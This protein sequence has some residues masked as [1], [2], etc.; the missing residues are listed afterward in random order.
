MLVHHVVPWKPL[1]SLGRLGRGTHE[2]PMTGGHVVTKGLLARLQT[3]HGQEEQVERFLHSTLPLV[4]QEP[5]T[6]AFFAIRFGRHEY[7]IFDVCPGES[8]VAAHLA[9][10]AATGLTQ[11]G[12]ELFAEAPEITRLDV[13]ASKLPT[14]GVAADAVTKGLLLLL[15]AKSG[16]EADVEEF[17]RGAQSIVEEEPGTIAWFAIKVGDGRYGIFDVFPDNAA[18]FAH[19]TGHVPRELAKHAPKLLGGLPDMD[20]LNVLASKLPA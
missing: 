16:H 7:G 1:V 3:K 9:G 8:A 17:L 4:E 18:R 19:L 12:E 11:R 6:T 5:G 20:M 10:P 2:I 15:P 14:A 13:L